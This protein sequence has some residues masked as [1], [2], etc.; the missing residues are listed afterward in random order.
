MSIKLDE[1]IQVITTA[2]E[3]FKKDGW[4]FE[5]IGIKEWAVPREEWSFAVATLTMFEGSLPCF[6]KFRSTPVG[7]ELEVQLEYP[8]ELN[9]FKYLPEYA[10]IVRQLRVPV[11]K[12]GEFLYEKF[13]AT[14]ATFLVGFKKAYQLY[15]GE[16]EL[17][18]LKLTVIKRLAGIFK[19]D[20]GE[21]DCEKQEQEFS[22]VLE[23][24]SI[25]PTIQI[26]VK[27]DEA[28]NVKLELNNLTEEE[29]VKILSFL[30]GK[31]ARG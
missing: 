15:R 5:Q 14:V 13:K 7:S 23:R 16:I 21:L 27:T 31:N 1:A 10:N 29:G 19:V 18:K 30:Y 4:D 24:K 17:K 25:G 28:H 12:G 22:A 20:L 8:P 2:S 3:L 11:A 6:I 26:R 9:K